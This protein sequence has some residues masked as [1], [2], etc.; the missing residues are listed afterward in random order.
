M[1]HLTEEKGHQRWA[2]RG[3]RHDGI[4]NPLHCVNL[5]KGEVE[6]LRR[7]QV[8]R[9]SQGPPGSYLR[10]YPREEH[11]QARLETARIHPTLL[12]V[13]LA[14]VIAVTTAVNLAA[15]VELDAPPH[16][17]FVLVPDQPFWAAV[18][19]VLIVVLHLV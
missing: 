4:T 1:P 5:K 18:G 17:G 2:R 10:R 8:T 6:E 19:V 12:P 14:V 7:P 11:H 13:V 15:E 16:A 9:V 3:M